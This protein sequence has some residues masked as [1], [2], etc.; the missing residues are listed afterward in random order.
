MAQKIET[1]LIDDID[2]SHADTTIRFGLNGAEYEID[3]NATH[4][5]ELRKAVGQ[6]LEVGRRA[7]GNARRASQGTARRSTGG[8]LKSSEIR[9]WAKSQ[10]MDV[11]ERGRIPSELVVKFRAATSA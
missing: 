10:G 6:Y 5:E 4:A 9:D 8:G 2:G 11:K 7:N 1:V 3:L